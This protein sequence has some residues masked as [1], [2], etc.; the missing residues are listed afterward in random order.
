MP[1]HGVSLRWV[2]GKWTTDVSSNLYFFSPFEN[3]M[4]VVAHLKEE[5]KFGVLSEV[6]LA[7]GT[8]I[9]NVV[10]ISLSLHTSRRMMKMC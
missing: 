3:T 9:M 1:Y 2:H 7:R 10:D 6:I 4:M 5:R 8:L